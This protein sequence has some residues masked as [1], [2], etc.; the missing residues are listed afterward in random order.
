VPRSLAPSPL[1]ENL[2]RYIGRLKGATSSALNKLPQNKSRTH[3]WAAKFWRVFLFDNRSLPPVRNY[4][5]HHNTRRRIPP[6]PFDWITPLN[7]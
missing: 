7:I 4:I 3:N 5:T 6:N 2:D 1:E